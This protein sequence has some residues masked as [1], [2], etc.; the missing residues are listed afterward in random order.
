[1]RGHGDR[2]L[3]PG[4]HSRRVSNAVYDAFYTGVRSRPTTLA[5]T[6]ESA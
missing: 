5:I 1:M 6:R 2:D 3:R 4:S